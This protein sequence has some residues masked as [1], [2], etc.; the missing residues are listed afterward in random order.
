MLNIDI[1]NIPENKSMIFTKQPLLPHI[2]L[3][4]TA[5]VW[6]LLGR[7]ERSCCPW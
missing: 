5:V 7:S 3:L 4:C 2:I 6:V 1:L